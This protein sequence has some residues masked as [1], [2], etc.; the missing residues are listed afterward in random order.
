[1]ATTSSTSQVKP[2]AGFT[3]DPL[4]GLPPLTVQFTDLSTGGPVSWTWDFGDGDSETSQNPSHTYDTAGSYTVTL[5]VVNRQGTSGQRSEASYISVEEDTATPTETST[6]TTTPTGSTTLATAFSG[7]PLNGTSPLTVQ[8]T[9]S[10]SGTPSEW[11]WDFGDANTSSVQNPSHVYSNPGLYTV[12]LKVTKSGDS[13]KTTK[14]SYITVNSGPTTLAAVNPVNTD[15]SGSQSGTLRKKSELSGTTIPTPIIRQ[16]QAQA[17]VTAVLTGQAWIDRENKKLA[18]AEAAATS[19][20]FDIVA[21][22]VGFFKGLF[23]WK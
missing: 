9:D 3:A 22:I 19:Q 1:V 14:A 15:S 6:T 12:S 5:T 2:N 23:S 21:Q 11:S 16:T 8:F 20:H 17:N 10:S 7:Y 18:D 13:D 4:S